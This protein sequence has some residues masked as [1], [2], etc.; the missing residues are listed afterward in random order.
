MMEAEK[1]RSKIVHTMVGVLLS[2]G[3]LAQ[4]IDFYNN[5]SIVDGNNFDTVN[6][7][8]SA[9]VNMTG[10]VISSAVNTHNTSVL[11][12]SGGDLRGIFIDLYDSSALSLSGGLVSNAW[13]YPHYSTVDIYGRDL[14]W[15]VDSERRLQGY[16]ADGTYFKIT[17]ARIENA[18]IVLHEIPEPTTLMLMGAGLGILLKYSRK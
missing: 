4:A 2:C 14:T 18:N 7:W 10:G 17:F 11:N 16:W 8:N 5:G 15:I 1:M 3:G 6:I 9:T 12:V 13:I